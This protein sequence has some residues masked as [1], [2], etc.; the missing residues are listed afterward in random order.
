[1]LLNLQDIS[2]FSNNNFDTKSWIN[3]ILKNAEDKKEVINLIR[4]LDH[5]IN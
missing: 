5:S 4:K 3:D 1:M 2:A